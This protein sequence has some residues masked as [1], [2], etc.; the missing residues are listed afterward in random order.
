[1]RRRLRAAGASLATL[2]TM[3]APGASGGRMRR[4]AILRG[5]ASLCVAPFAWASAADPQPARVAYVTGG[6]VAL[7]ATWLDAFRAGMADLGYREGR[8]L[9]F[10]AYG[11]KGRFDELPQILDLALKARPDVLVVSTTPGAL[12]ARQATRTVPT[13]FV[14]VGDP[15]SIGL[16]DNLARP[17]GNMTGLTNSTIELTG[18]RLQVLK[19]ALPGTRR[20]TLLVNPDDPN[21]GLQIAAGEA[22]AAELGLEV[23]TVAA[24]R[25]ASDLAPAFVEARRQGAD[26]ALRLVDP[27]ASALREETTRL[28]LEYRMPVVY[29]FM[30]DAVAGGVLSYGTSQAEMYRRVASF[31][32]RPLAWLELAG[33]LL[34]TPVLA[35]VRT[36]RR[37]PIWL[38]RPP[39]DLRAGCQSS[40]RQSAWHFLHAG[41]SRPGGPGDRMSVDKPDPVRHPRRRL[42]RKYVLLLASL[43]GGTLL[44]S[45]G[46]EIWFSYA[47]NKTA[48]ARLQ[49][50]KA[51]SAAA[52]IDQFIDEI[53]RQIGWTTR[54]Q[55]SPSVVEQRRIE[56]LQL[57]RQAPAV[58]EVAHLDAAGLQDVR[59][60]RLAMDTIGSRADFSI[61]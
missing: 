34:T 14:A 16:V 60:S 9:V 41:V 18:K 56:Y 24:L 20:I 8:N 52:R 11:A 46:L 53:S 59:V 22:A 26:A 44:A 45:G 43:V 35:T 19:E 49:A 54:A 55:W 58:T 48:L 42:F 28:T 10:N 21:A 5:A 40:H 36:V 47:E 57:L 6:D 12:A 13:V 23:A 38:G 51:T 50:E 31:V 29:A 17:G 39:D 30:E 4:R 32:Q 25:R 37:L 2:L 15:V 1:M 3:G 27:Q 7:R 61:G 33:L